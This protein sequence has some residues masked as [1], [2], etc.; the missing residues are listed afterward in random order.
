MIFRKSYWRTGFDDFLAALLSIQITRTPRIFVWNSKKY[1]WANSTELR[2]DPHFLA[3]NFALWKQMV[4]CSA[5]NS[6]L[7]RTPEVFHPDAVKSV[8]FID[9]GTTVCR[10]LRTL[11]H[12]QYDQCAKRIQRRDCQWCESKPLAYSTPDSGILYRQ[13]TPSI[14]C[15][16]C[17]QL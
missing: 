10:V 4:G 16:V 9:G 2:F 6:A 14:V 3:Y 7:S 8:R 11:W 1:W 13:T 5:K 17:I 12:D 15:S